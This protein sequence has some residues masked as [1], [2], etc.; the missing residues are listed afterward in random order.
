MEEFEN[1]AFKYWIR[2]G[3]MHNYDAYVKW[4]KKST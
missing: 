3:K 1:E 2:T 4:I